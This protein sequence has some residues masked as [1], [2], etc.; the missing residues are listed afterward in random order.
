[1][2]MHDVRGI[3]PGEI[4]VVL[5]FRRDQGNWWASGSSCIA[6]VLFLPFVGGIRGDPGGAPRRLT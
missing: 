2:I 5:P 1:M 6:L 4:P 3:R